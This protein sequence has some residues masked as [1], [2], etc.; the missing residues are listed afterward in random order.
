[1][2]K[3]YT[4]QVLTEWQ[5]SPVGTPDRYVLAFSHHVL[6]DY[7][8]ARLLLRGSPDV[9]VTRLT[10]DPELVI[11]IRPSLLLHFRHL[12]TDDPSRTPFWQLVFQIIRSDEIPEIGKLIGPAVGAEMAGVLPDLEPLCTALENTDAT[13]RSAAEQALGHLVGA[14]LAVP[15]DERTLIGPDAGP[16]CELLERVS[17]QLRAKEAYTV[18]S[19]LS[20]IC[21][22]PEAFT[23]EQRLNAGKTARRVLEFAWL[24]TPR[25]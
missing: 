4:S 13:P 18:R 19:L 17:R 1:L 21:D 6:F 11:V 3:G 25:D 15:S 22:H 24:Y 5:S 20:T 14:L 8:V 2:T 10:D 9:P 23:T 12:W 16:W 7:A